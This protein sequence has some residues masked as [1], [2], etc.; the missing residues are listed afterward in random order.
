MRS[1][2]SSLACQRTYKTCKVHVT[3]AA[4][5]LSRGEGD[6]GLNKVLYGSYARSPIP[7]AG[8]LYQNYDCS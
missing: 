3:M 8:L 5:Y 1:L 2:T 6:A 7:V 4:V